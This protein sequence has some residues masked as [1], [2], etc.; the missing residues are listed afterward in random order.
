MQIV[1]RAW[2]CLFLF[3]AC[4]KQLQPKVLPTTLIS[5]D[6][7]PRLAPFVDPSLFVYL[8]IRDLAGVVKKMGL[9]AKAQVLERM[10]IHLSDLRP[11][12][13]TTIFFWQ[14]SSL[15]CKVEKPTGPPRIV[16]LCHSLRKALPPKRSPPS[17]SLARVKFKMA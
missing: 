3:P 7:L 4:A 9:T 1:R 8:R 17:R 11:E 13:I 10:G 16:A 12:E 14:S 15:S 2:F 6:S 5:P